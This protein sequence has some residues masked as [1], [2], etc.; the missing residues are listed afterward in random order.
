MSYQLTNIVPSIDGVLLRSTTPI[1]GATETLRYLQQQKIPFILLTNGGGKGEAERVKDLSEKLEV[2][3]DTSMFVQ[4]HTPFV[5][6]ANG[7]DSLAEKCILVCGGDGGKCRD[8]AESY[9]FKNVITPGDIYV[10]YPE[11]WPFSSNFKTY[12]SSFAR[13]LPRPIS[14]SSPGESLKIDAIFVFNDP[15]DWALD[16]QVILDVLLS[17]KGIIGKQ[18]R[19]NNDWSLPNRGYL[20]DQQPPIYFSNPDL[21]WAAK[22]HLPRLGQGGFREALEGLWAALTG[23]PR[24]GVE[25]QKKV[26]GKPFRQTYSF[27]ERRLI[28]H[29]KNI[30][31]SDPP[32]L[33]KVYMV[34]DNPESDIRGANTYNSPHETEWISILVKTG[35]YD[36]GTPAWAPRSLQEDVKGAVQ[37]ALED[38]G[39]KAP[40]K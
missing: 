13:P 28:A 2:P 16:A 11:I 19:K 40:F 14:P 31:Q 35:V 8:V 39:W 21:L 5:E 29:R 7:K 3:L 33:R 37:W 22:Y 9:G 24:E 17:E 32:A 34:G 23:G 4:S 15:R 10:A 30:Y 27:A 26:F 1:P 6:L 20:Q 25:L 12:Y 18:S 36:E 38:S